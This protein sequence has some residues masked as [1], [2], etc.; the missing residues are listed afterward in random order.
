MTKITAILSAIFLS[1]ILGLAA[2]TMSAPASA[3]HKCNSTHTHY[4]EGN[5]YKV[6]LGKEKDVGSGL[7]GCYGT[8]WKNVAKR[9]SKKAI[10]KW[11]ANVFIVTGARI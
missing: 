11:N 2:I 10:W 8:E 7:R 1:L 4:H 9:G 3:H 6:A 5:Q